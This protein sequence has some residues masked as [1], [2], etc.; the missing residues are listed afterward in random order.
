M[1]ESPSRKLLLRRCDN[2]AIN[3]VKA[4]NM[5]LCITASISSARWKTV[6]LTPYVL[7]YVFKKSQ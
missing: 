7:T 1:Q 3:T 5:F 2:L 4:K 6:V